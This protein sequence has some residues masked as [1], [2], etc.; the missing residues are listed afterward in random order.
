M[1]EDPANAD[2]Q[3]TRA[4]LLQRL[5]LPEVREKLKRAIC[6]F[7]TELNQATIEERWGWLRDDAEFGLGEYYDEFAAHVGA[8]AIPWDEAN[9]LPNSHWHFQPREFITT[10]RKCGWL[11]MDEAFQLFP[12]HALRRDNHGIWLNE[13]VQPGRARLQRHLPSL[14]KSC[15]RYGIVTPLRQAAFYANAMQE[16]MWF[17]TLSEGNPGGNWYHPWHG[18]GFLQLTHPDN[19]IK[20]WRFI[21]R[22]V[23]HNAE[24]VLITA[25]TNAD[26]LRQALA[27]PVAERTAAQNGYVRA[28]SN[29][30]PA[31][32][33]AN[34]YL[35]RVD[36]NANVV[37][38]GVVAWR[39][40]LISDQVNSYHPAN[41]AGVYWAWSGAAAAADQWPQNVRATVGTGT[42]TF[43]Y[44]TS[45]GM[46]RVAG[47][48]NV[49]HPT[50]NYATIN[51]IQARFQAYTSSVM[52]LMDTIT[53]P[54]ANAV[55]QP[56]PENYIQRRP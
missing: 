29:A 13:Q 21:G 49:G 42:N 5:R 51:G 52:V 53:F 18:R 8:L 16:T 20:Y 40:E 31:I 38:S 3:L 28:A 37:A 48:V 41:S 4:E 17:G 32:V 24:T 25:K 44:Y 46:G 55:P 11:A 22:T 10:W 35:T 39:N 23:S 47:T 7:P 50:N 9:W 1:I 2:G 54:N 27:R 14:N 33:R 30:I 6:K 43:M 26:N 12:S 19:Y 56:N 15:R 45:A 34:E 36:N